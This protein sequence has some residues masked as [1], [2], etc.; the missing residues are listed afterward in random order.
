MKASLVVVSMFHG[1][2]YSCYVVKKSSHPIR[3]WKTLPVIFIRA[4][5]P[6]KCVSAL[7]TPFRVPK[8]CMMLSMQLSLRKCL[9]CKC[10][11][12]W[13][14]N[15]RNGF[16]SCIEYDGLLVKI[17]HVCI[18]YFPNFYT[19]KNSFGENDIQ[20]L[21]MRHFSSC[22]WLQTVFHFLLFA[23]HL[24][25]WRSCLNYCKRRITQD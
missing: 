9:P 8:Y 2:E 10:V 23:Q 12:L 16:N 22:W 19:F 17:L 24:G 15:Q 13:M 3:H 14:A 6:C 18:S 7:L 20:G 11:C 1:G 5:W 21:W 25:P 4:C